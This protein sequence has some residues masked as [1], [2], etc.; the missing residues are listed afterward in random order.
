MWIYRRNFGEEQLWT[1]GYCAPGTN[2]FVTDSD[3][4]VREEAASRVAWLN[5][6]GKIDEHPF[7]E[8]Y[9]KS[10]LEMLPA[11]LELNDPNY[12]FDFIEG[13]NECLELVKKVVE[14]LGVRTT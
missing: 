2:Q 11:P 1:V 12:F 6:S 7:P 10:V 13:Y 5:G 3:H 4:N 9:R 14:C 8:A